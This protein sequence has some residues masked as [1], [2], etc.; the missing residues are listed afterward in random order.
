MSPNQHAPGPQPSRGPAVGAAPV[1]RSMCLKIRLTSQPEIQA[2]DFFLSRGELPQPLGDLSQIQRYVFLLIRSLAQPRAGGQ[3]RFHFFGRTFSARRARGCGL[4]VCQ[5][6]SELLQ[7]YTRSG[8]AM[9]ARFAAYPATAM[10]GHGPVPGQ[11]SECR[12]LSSPL[13]GFLK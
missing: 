3:L 11:R 4:G 6:K 12:L 13:V 2:D 7:T 5:I 10:Q 1:N 9:P 8:P